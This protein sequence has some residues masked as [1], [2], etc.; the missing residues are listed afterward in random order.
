LGT[1]TRAI[2][3]TITETEIIVEEVPIISGV[4]IFDKINQKKYPK[5]I[6]EIESIKRYAA[7]LPAF[8]FLKLLH[9]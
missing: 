8:I 6:P 1:P 2:A 4:V 7:P 3:I 5:K 9:L